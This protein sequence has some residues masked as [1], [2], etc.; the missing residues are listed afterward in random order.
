MGSDKNLNNSFSV[1]IPTLGGDALGRTIGLIN[2]GTLVPDEILICIPADFVNRLD[3]L[4]SIPNV[5]IIATACK[6]QVKQRIEGF[7]QV[8]T[9][10][11]IQLDDDIYVDENCFENLVKGIAGFEEDVCIAPVLVFEPS[12]LSCYETIHDDSFIQRLIHGKNWLRPGNITRSGI[13]IGCNAF[14]S[15]HRF[16]RVEWL[17]GGC[18]VYKKHTLLLTDFYPFAGKAFYEDVIQSIHLKNNGIK[19]LIDNTAVCGIDPFETQPYSPLFYITTFHQQYKYR[20]HIVTLLG[21]SQLY[22]LMDGIFMYYLTALN[23]AKSM[24]RPLVNVVRNKH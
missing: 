19:L 5:R 24:L 10:Y 9:D 17:A 14:T 18:V 4:R 15:N 7:K 11:A 1:V 2:S 21:E 3:Q 22:L 13:N 8:R 6:G 16:T 12:R 23:F 20:K